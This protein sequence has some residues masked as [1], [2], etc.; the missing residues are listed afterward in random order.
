MYIPLHIFPN[1]SRSLFEDHTVLRDSLHVVPHPIPNYKCIPTEYKSLNMELMHDHHNHF[2]SMYI[3][4]IQ[5][6]T[7]PLPYMH[8]PL[9]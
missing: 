3:L 2:R 8:V 4:R 6:L 9:G 7:P 1:L 5:E